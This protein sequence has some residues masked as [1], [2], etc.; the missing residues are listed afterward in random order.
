MLGVIGGVGFF[1]NEMFKEAACLEIETPYGPSEIF[2]TENILFLPRHGIKNRRPPHMVNHRA[3]LMALKERGIKRIIGMNS[4]GSLKLEIPPPSI[5]IPDDYINFVDIATYHDSKIVHI[6]PSL[7]ENLRNDLIS[8]AKME[9]LDVIENGIYIQ[10]RG[11]R[12]ETKAEISLFKNFGDI[13][14]MTMASEATLARELDLAYASICSVD[15]YANGI[16]KEALTN[17]NIL[18]NARVNSDRIKEFIFKIA[19]EL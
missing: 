8:H 17:D 4:V 12:L 10:T 13:V 16:V 9:S 5:L 19:G 11:P 7:D 1:E 18:A 15:N 2:E 6:V 3:N 14:G